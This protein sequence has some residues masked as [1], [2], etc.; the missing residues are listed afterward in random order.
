MRRLR[1]SQ[2]CELRLKMQCLVLERQVRKLSGRRAAAR[3][4]GPKPHPYERKEQGCGG[5]T[6]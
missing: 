6:V 4:V 5:H 1:H 3:A 2:S